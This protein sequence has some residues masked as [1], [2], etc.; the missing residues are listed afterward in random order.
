MAMQLAK[1]SST[2]KPSF[3]APALAGAF[4]LPSFTCPA[5]PRTSSAFNG[6]FGWFTGIR[7]GFHGILVEHHE[8]YV[9]IYIYALWYFN[10]DMENHLHTNFHGYLN[11]CHVCVC[12]VQYYDPKF[13]QTR[14]QNKNECLKMLAI[15]SIN[16]YSLLLRVCIYIYINTQ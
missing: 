3:E 14:T 5:K 6:F 15:H 16:C 2:G 1:S 13:R 7:M 9:Y 11:Y 10:I 12:G 8:L 4:A